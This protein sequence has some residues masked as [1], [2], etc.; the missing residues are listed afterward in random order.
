MTRAWG[1]FAAAQEGRTAL[2]LASEGNHVEAV[3]LLLD[4]QPELAIAKDR[5]MNMQ[6]CSS[7]RDTAC[8]CAAQR[9]RTALHLAVCEVHVEIVRVM[10]EHGLRWGGA[11]KVFADVSRKIATQQNNLV[12]LHALLFQR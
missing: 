12:A 4:H 1:L 6:N 2:H 5:V 7:G 8:R 3:R 11:R 10:L 9:G